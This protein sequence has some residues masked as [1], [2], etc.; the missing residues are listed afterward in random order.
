M[1]RNPVCFGRGSW[2]RTHAGILPQRI[3]LPRKCSFGSAGSWTSARIN[4]PQR[5]SNAP[6]IRTITPL[7][8]FQPFPAQPDRRIRMSNVP[9]SPPG[10]IANC[11]AEDFEV[12]RCEAVRVAGSMRLTLDSPRCGCRCEKVGEMS[13]VRRARLL[14]ISLAPIIP[15]RFGRPGALAATRQESFT[16][17]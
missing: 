15:V 6:V 3:F 13:D 16:D 11:C 4:S 7:R 17:G 9:R 5:A 10:P 8:A 1:D 14:A 2:V 12:V